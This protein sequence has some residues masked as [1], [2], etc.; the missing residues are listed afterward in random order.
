M[1]HFVRLDNYF[2]HVLNKLKLQCC[3]VGT[4]VQLPRIR[5]LPIVPL[6]LLLAADEYLGS[7]IVRMR[8]VT[9]YVL[10]NYM[11]HIVCL[12]T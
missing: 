8:R 5:Y 12:C 4:S 1:H 10:S 3:F 6:N 9:Y 2:G 7:T 11:Y